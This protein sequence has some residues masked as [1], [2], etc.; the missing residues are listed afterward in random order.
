LNA[1]ALVSTG[2]GIVG[3]NMFVYCLNNPVSNKDDNG[4]ICSY[5]SDGGGSSRKNKSNPIVKNVIYYGTKLI[6]GVSDYYIG[7]AIAKFYKKSVT[8]S[9]KPVS[10]SLGNIRVETFKDTPKTLKVANT[11]TKWGAGAISAG[12]TIYSIWDN[13]MNY[14]SNTTFKRSMVDAVG[15][16]FGC[17]AAVIAAESSLPVTFAAGLTIGVGILIGISVD[18][19]KESI[20]N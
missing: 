14:D 9:Y 7:N 1:D 15:F 4:F 20:S 5:M 6:Q 13:K 12:M 18:M 11:V 10:L 17:A 16:G 2:Q 3:S 19:F 8:Q